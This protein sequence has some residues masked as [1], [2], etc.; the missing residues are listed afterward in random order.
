MGPNKKRR[1]N[2]FPGEGEKLK[3]HATQNFSYSNFF[4]FL[5][6]N[7]ITSR[8]RIRQFDNNDILQQLENVGDTRK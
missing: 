3:S 7:Q 2:H 6:G 1:D 4:H 5:I 8:R